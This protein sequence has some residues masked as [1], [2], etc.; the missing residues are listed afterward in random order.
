MKIEDKIY[1]AVYKRFVGSIKGSA[2]KPR[3]SR[4]TVTLQS[5]TLKID[6]TLKKKLRK[7]SPYLFFLLPA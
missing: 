6:A 3:R 5:L 7:K 1:I 4:L 2:S